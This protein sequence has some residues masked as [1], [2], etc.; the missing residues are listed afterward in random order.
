MDRYLDNRGVP[1]K[2]LRVFG[3]V[4]WIVERESVVISVPLVC[5]SSFMQVSVQD[6]P[7][8]GREPASE[9]RVHTR[10]LNS[11]LE[12][13]AKARPV[14]FGEPIALRLIG[15]GAV[16][17]RSRRRWVGLVKWIPRVCGKSCD[18]G[19]R[20]LTD[21]PS[22]HSATVNGVSVSL[23]LWSL[24]HASIVRGRECGRCLAVRKFVGG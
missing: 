16:L 9:R 20:L 13:G 4:L 11:G 6:H 17:G 23:V 19:C 8:S 18:R 14:T 12:S 24:C 10:R 1:Q 7:R 5:Q 2:V 21:G 22:C 15:L 3:I